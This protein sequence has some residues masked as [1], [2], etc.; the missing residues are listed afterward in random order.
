MRLP[1]YGCIEVQHD[2]ERSLD[3]LKLLKVLPFVP[4]VPYAL[5]SA[6]SPDMSCCSVYE[7]PLIGQGPLAMH[8]S[9]SLLELCKR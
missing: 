9:S 2:S 7:S 6:W 1:L 5:P 3:G 8:S 4:A